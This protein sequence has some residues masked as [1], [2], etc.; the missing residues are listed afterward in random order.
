MQPE[1][2]WLRQRTRFCQ[3]CHPLKA[4]AEK[5]MN[6]TWRRLEACASARAR[7]A[8]SRE[9]CAAYITR[10]HIACITGR[11]AANRIHNADTI[12][13]PTHL[14]CE[15]FLQTQ[16]LSLSLHRV[17]PAQ[18]RFIVVLHRGTTTLSSSRKITHGW[19]CRHAPGPK[20]RHASSMWWSVCAGR[21]RL[22]E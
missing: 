3:R 13:V 16:N 22:R 11:I 4:A 15:L 6:R 21:R 18:L 19:S 17:A 1:D 8:S 14:V 9:R 7:A 20:T 10:E 12:R 2:V 5:I